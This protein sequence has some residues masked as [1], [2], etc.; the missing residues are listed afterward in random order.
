M[1]TTPQP[2][3]QRVAQRAAFMAK[4]VNIEVKAVIENMSWF[5][6]DDKKKYYLFGH[7]GG[8]DLAKRL[9]VPLI[10][11]IPLLPEI[12]EGS[13]TGSPL[14]AAMPESEGG[15]IFA[16]ISETIDIDLAPTR[17]YNKGLKLLQ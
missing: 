7:G 17:R 16:Q 14:V 4:N 8:E 9:E 13:D 10:G 2:A 5:T 6:G 15:A 12:R 1:V 11:Q 3:A